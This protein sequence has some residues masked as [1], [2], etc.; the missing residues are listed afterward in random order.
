[1]ASTHL[2]PTAPHQHHAIGRALM[3]LAVILVLIALCATRASAMV[4]K[5]ES[6]DHITPMSAAEYAKI[7]ARI[8]GPEK[9]F[10]VVQRPKLVRWIPNASSGW[11]SPWPH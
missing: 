2:M 11:M 6:G 3:V 7:K 8:R 10:H 1:M 4:T 5:A 9:H